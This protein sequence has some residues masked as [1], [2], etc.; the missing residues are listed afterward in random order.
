M[1]TKLIIAAISPYSIAVDPESSLKK[2]AKR[3]LIARRPL[4][5]LIR[6]AREVFPRAL[7]MQRMRAALRPHRQ[8]RWQRD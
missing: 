1:I 3:L 6:A 8:Q 2:L 5:G 4:T 7:D